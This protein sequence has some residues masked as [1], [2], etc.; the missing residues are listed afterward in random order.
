MLVALPWYLWIAIGIAPIALDGVSQVISQP[1]FHLLAYRESTPFLR[2]LTGGLFGFMTAW[3][4]YSQVEIAMQ[5]TRRILAVKF[6]RA[7]SER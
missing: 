3:F 2:T 6:A 5:E 1:P 7:K 4:G